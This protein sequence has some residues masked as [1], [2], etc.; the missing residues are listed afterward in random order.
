MADRGRPALKATERKAHTVA[1][2]LDIGE[3]QRLKARRQPGE[4][5]HQTARRLVLEALDDGADR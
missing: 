5:V 2:R 1:F 3:I 4:T